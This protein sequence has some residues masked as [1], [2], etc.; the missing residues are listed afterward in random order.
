MYENCGKPNEPMFLTKEDFLILLNIPL[1]VQKFIVKIYDWNKLVYRITSFCLKNYLIL[2]L[3][4]YQTKRH[5]V[6]HAYIS[7]V[8][9]I[10][11]P[12][13]RG[14]THFCYR[15][16]HMPHQTFILWIVKI[17][18]LKHGFVVQRRIYMIVHSQSFFVFWMKKNYINI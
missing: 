16:F 17:S 6:V 4:K 11:F 13:Q 18:F 8:K 9:Q 15:H 12:D 2:Y 5:D 14:I 7:M 3:L 10:L 1:N